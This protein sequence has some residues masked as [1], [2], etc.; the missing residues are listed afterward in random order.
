VSESEEK[1]CAPKVAQNLLKINNFLSLDTLLFFSGTTQPAPKSI[2]VNV[3][4]ADK[5]NN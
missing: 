2:P 3:A 4:G 1:L 5:Q